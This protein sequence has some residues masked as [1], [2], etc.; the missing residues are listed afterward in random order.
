M[1]SGFECPSAIDW[2]TSVD[3][4]E[5]S[6]VV[7]TLGALI[8]LA[9]APRT[10]LPVLIVNHVT[11]STRVIVDRFQPRPL[12]IAW[13]GLI[14]YWRRIDDRVAMFAPRRRIMSC[15]VCIRVV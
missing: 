14:P 2:N 8:A 12:V 10:A 13:I 11:P 5:R 3:R 6:G 9:T 15:P 1:P 7:S 4:G